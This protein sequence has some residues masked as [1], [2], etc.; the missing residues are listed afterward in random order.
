VATPFARR[1]GG[2]PLLD[3]RRDSRLEGNA[4][5]PSLIRVPDWVQTRLAR[6]YLYFAHH[7][8]DRIRL[9]IADRIEGPWTLHESGALTLADSLFPTERPREADLD[10]R[11]KSIVAAGHDGTYPHIASPDVVFDASSRTIRLY[12]H[13]RETDG[14]QVTRVAI[15]DDGLHFRAR[16]EV[17]GPSY[18]RVFTYGGIWYALAMPG[19]L[20]RSFDG[21]TDFEAGPRLF[22]PD[23]RHSAVLV[24]DGALHVFWTQVGQAP[25]Q[26]LYSTIPLDGDWRAWRESEPVVV[27]RPELPWEG[28]DLPV[29]PSRRGSIM[30]PVNQLRDPALFEEDGRLYLLY[31]G[32]GEQAIGLAELTGL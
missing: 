10:P 7:E 31:C 15:S 1:I 3:V 12:Y 32:A 24:R 5:G 13:G 9:A 22:G 17:L 20:L 6:Y 28:A 2:E 21:L 18:F 27:L 26:I 25:E 8:G 29:L 11:V 4:N 14:T 30:K 16:T 23:M 19:V